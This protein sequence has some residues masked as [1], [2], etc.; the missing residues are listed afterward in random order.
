M[1]YSGSKYFTIT[2]ARG[3]FFIRY[4][5]YH[6]VHGY[7]GW[8]CSSY[9]FYS[10][11]SNVIEDIPSAAAPMM[12]RSFVSDHLRPTKEQQNSSVLI[13]VMNRL[14]VACREL[15]CFSLLSSLFQIWEINWEG[16]LPSTGNAHFRLVSSTKDW[17]PC[18]QCSEP[19]IR[20]ATFWN[21]RTRVIAAL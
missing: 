19:K 6:E 7:N 20:W 4:E 13:S 15:K 12:Q 21:S 9:V 8:V 16:L 14:S 3:C 5:F 2:I 11:S 18:V 10:T 1:S 17:I